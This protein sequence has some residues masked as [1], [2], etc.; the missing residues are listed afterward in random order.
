MDFP[1]DDLYSEVKISITLL[2]EREKCLKTD[3]YNL[4]RELDEMKS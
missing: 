4:L 2:I 1:L 3:R